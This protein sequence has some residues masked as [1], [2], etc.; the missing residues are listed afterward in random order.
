[1]NDTRANH[2]APDG[3]MGFKFVPGSAHTK[4]VPSPAEREPNHVPGAGGGRAARSPDAANDIIPSC[5]GLPPQA[6]AV[7]NVLV[8]PRCSVLSTRSS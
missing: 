1:M 3:L 7:L 8:I 5:V 6:D 2:T 4:P